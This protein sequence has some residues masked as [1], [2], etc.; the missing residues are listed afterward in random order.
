MKTLGQF[1][2]AWAAGH[3]TRLGYRIVDR[4]VRYRCGEIDLIAWDGKTLVFVEVKCR[5]SSRYGRP[6]ASITPRRFAHLEN[7]IQ[8]YLQEKEMEPNDFRVDVVSIEL[9][10]TGRVTHSEVLRNVEAPS[11]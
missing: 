8:C 4:N 5:R 9:D 1:G 3:L 11:W 10:S 2:E 6:E 7:A